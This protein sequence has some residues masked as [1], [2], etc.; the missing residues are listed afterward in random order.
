MQIIALVIFAVAGLLP[1]GCSYLIRDPQRKL[2]LA[3]G[4]AWSLLWWLANLRIC[5]LPSASEASPLYGLILPA[6]LI[7][8]PLLTAHRPG[9]IWH[10]LIHLVAAGLGAGG[11]ILGM[12]LM[13]I[14]CHG[15]WF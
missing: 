8:I 9:W 14:G 1:G 3:A 15:F 10:G 6:G 11:L 7:G 13:E 5:A 4:L 2:V 12:I